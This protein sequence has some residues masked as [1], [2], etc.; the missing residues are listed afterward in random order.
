MSIPS[1]QLSDYQYLLPEEK[2]AKFPLA[3]RD[4]S[5]LLHFEKG[6]ISHH[7][8]TELPDLLPANTLMVFNNTKVIPARLIFTR[9]SGAKVEIFLLK[10]F[11]PSP[12]INEVMTAT[13]SVSWETMIGNL[14][15]WKSGEVLHGKIQIN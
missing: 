1:I 9:T 12:V 2:I 10:P 8:F 14:K 15:K 6:S 4:Q 3:K 7:Q 13:R 5:K 11:L